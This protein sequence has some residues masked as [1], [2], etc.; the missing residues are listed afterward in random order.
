MK[1]AIDAN[2]RARSDSEIASCLPT[3]D[4]S[5]HKSDNCVRFFI[6][7]ERKI[8]YVKKKM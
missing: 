1:Q 8:G 2:V 6:N 3:G 5:S 7:L 4:D